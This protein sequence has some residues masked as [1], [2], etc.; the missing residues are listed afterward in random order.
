MRTG[1]AVTL[2]VSRSKGTALVIIAYLV[3][4]FIDVGVHVL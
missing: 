3:V 1:D 2:D 4:S